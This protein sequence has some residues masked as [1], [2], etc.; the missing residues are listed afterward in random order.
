MKDKICCI[1]AACIVLLLINFFPL[2][3]GGN[4]IYSPFL[5]ESN[6]N[7]VKIER[8]I[9]KNKHVE[10]KLLKKEQKAEEI[11]WIGEI[12]GSNNTES[13]PDETYIVASAA[14]ILI[15]TIFLFM[16]SFNHALSFWMFLV[17]L[18]FL[19]EWLN[20]FDFSLISFEILETAFAFIICL[21][22]II[23][24]G[25]KDLIGGSKE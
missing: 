21:C 15:I 9:T 11:D 16:I 18:A 13:E 14:I 17:A 6:K 23:F 24:A 12:W 20:P 2:I 10:K 8:K 19:D 7:D 5:G 3:W 25:A 1:I 22:I 4:S